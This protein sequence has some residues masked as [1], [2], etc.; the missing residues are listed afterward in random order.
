MMAGPIDRFSPAFWPTWQ[1][2]RSPAPPGRAHLLVDAAFSTVW[3]TWARGAPE[4]SCERLFA[5]VCWTAPDALALSPL[6]IDVAAVGSELDTLL[7]AADGLPM[8]TGFV[9]HEALPEQAYRLSRWCRVEAGG[10]Q[11]NLRFADTR[12]LGPLLDSLTAE[13]RAAFLGPVASVHI[14][15]RQGEWARLAHV[16][17]DVPPAEQATL[18]EAQFARLLTE[19]EPDALLARIGI[20]SGVG[21]S[22]AWAAVAELMQAT[23]NQPGFELEDQARQAIEALANEKEHTP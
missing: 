8:L 15:T 16:G 22:R 20:P 11:F 18:T 13:Q 19:A 2:W 1:A 23:P 12:R 5:H 3:Q 14:Q 9:T 7:A 4:G 17:A 6:L 21:P 10:T